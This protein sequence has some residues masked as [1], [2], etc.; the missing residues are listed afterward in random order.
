MTPLVHS[1]Y[2]DDSLGTHR[3]VYHPRHRCTPLCG[4]N[5]G[6]THDASSSFAVYDAWGLTHDASSSLPDLNPDC[7]VYLV[8][9]SDDEDILLRTAS[10]VPMED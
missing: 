2:C 8:Q 6:L 1:A 9:D 4:P 7:C 3:G 10:E 5:G